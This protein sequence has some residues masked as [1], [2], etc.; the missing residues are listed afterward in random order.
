[1]FKGIIIKQGVQVT[2]ARDCRL[3]VTCCDKASAMTIA[4]S[5]GQFVAK[6]DGSALKS[7]IEQYG[8][9]ADVDASGET[10]AQMVQYF[11]TDW[12]YLVCRAEANG[13]IVLVDDESVSVRPPA[14]AK[15]TLFFSFG[16]TL[17][18]IDL[19]MDARTQLSAVTARSW[20]H[21][22]QALAAQVASEPAWQGQ[23]NVSGETL[24]KALGVSHFEMQSSGPLTETGLKSWADAQLVKSRLSRIRGR[25]ALIGN[26]DVKPGKLIELRGLGARFN[27]DAFVSRVQH[28]V[29]AGQWRTEVSFGLP[30][31]WFA[32]APGS[33]GSPA[34]SGLVP[35]AGGLQIGKVKQIYDDPDGQRRVK[36]SMPL[37][38]PD[39]DAIWMR[40]AGGYASVNAGVYFMPEI[41]DEVVVG[42][43][44]GD[45]GAP[46]VLGSLQSSLRKAPYVPEQTNA[47]KAI[48][49]KN[50]LKLIFDD[51]KKTICI[52]TPGAHSILMS[53]EDKSVTVKDTTGNKVLLDQSGITM[54]SPG[55]VTIS[56]KGSVHISGNAGIS[57]ELSAN[58][59]ISG[60]N[61][62]VKG[63]MSLSAQGQLQAEFKSGG[64]VTIQGLMVM[65]N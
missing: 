31:S 48:V 58:V 36:V 32:E 60:Q 44:N 29:E 3:V 1:M 21:A 16:A 12:D 54:S 42:F 57:V 56:A 35:S 40:L 43:L 19:E 7:L 25:G 11:A 13:A 14:F 2:R 49:T 45:P 15:P 10:H 4:R 41:D 9:T 38:A 22:T 33:V 27:G 24:S 61:T 47:K 5:K 53:D 30:S 17:V 34:A 52:E 18:D 51:E 23:G 37:L 62:S 59:A 50:Q 6:N 46:I 8:L 28:I 63:D 55:N 26:A 20:D 64:E 39:G 65:I